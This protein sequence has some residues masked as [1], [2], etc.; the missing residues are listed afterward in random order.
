MDNHSFNNINR[1]RNRRRHSAILN[2]DI[3][4]DQVDEMDY[5]VWF[6]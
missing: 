1:S 5:T 6:W 2:Y 4:P 3:L